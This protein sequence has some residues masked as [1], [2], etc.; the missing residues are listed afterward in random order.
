L[1]TGELAYRV[2]YTVGLRVFAVF[3]ILAFSNISDPRNLAAFLNLGVIISCVPWVLGGVTRFILQSRQSDSLGKP[4]VVFG[5]I[6]TG[7]IRLAI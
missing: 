7:T 1:I 3:A 5:R 6:R 2:G 4:S